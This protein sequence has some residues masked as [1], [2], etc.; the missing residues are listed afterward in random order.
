MAEQIM[1]IGGSGHAKVII[2]AILSSGDLVAGILD[3]NIPAGTKVLGIPVLGTIADY[4]HYPNY[5]YIVAIGNNSVRQRIAAELQVRWHTVIHPS[6]FVSRFAQIGEGSIIMPHAA[7]NAGAN[8]GRHC[9]INTGAIV[10]HENLIG[11]FAHLSPK[12]ALSGAVSIGECT[13]VGIGAVVRNNISITGN[14]MIGAGAVV[15][16]DIKEPG[17]YVGIPAKVL[18]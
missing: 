15:V 12:A 1:V 7:V 9:I 10:E 18:A 17:T 5:R 13:H 2:D 16:N 14:C 3:D 6:A 11:D 8:I 4:I